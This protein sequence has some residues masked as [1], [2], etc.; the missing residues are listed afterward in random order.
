MG[1][2]ARKV[3]PE[4][5]ERLSACWEMAQIDRSTM[6]KQLVLAPVND[7]FAPVGAAIFFSVLCFPDSKIKR[8]KFAD[9]LCAHILKAK[10]I[11]RSASRKELREIPG[12]ERLI[13]IPNKRIDQTIE[14]GLRR[15]HT[16]LR[17]AWVL[18]QKMSS[19][20]NPSDQES[21]HRFMSMAAAQNTHKYPA[22][23][24]ASDDDEQ[25]VNSFRRNVMNPAKPVAHLALALH[26]YL[27]TTG[28][29]NVGVFELIFDAHSWLPGVLEQSEQYR[30]FF[31]DLFP[32]W[33]NSRLRER[34]KNIRIKTSDMIAVLP[35]IDPISSSL[36][37]DQ[38]KDL[39]ARFSV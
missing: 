7:G 12:I 1:D 10:T 6:F 20:S 21:L 34:A 11:P 19:S 27:A 30:V 29:I 14:D 2:K 22:F 18:A 16:R 5:Y 24:S 33:N 4:I 31:G 26:N 35:Y 28:R 38:L 13:E 9:A 15:F 25:V 23:G 3:G 17:A 32:D 36:D 37:F 39:E 8:S